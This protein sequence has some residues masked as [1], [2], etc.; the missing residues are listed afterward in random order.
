MAV[1]IIVDESRSTRPKITSIC[2]SCKNARANR[3]AWVARKKQVWKRAYERECRASDRVQG[4]Y[5]VW[6][7]QKCAHFEVDK[8]AR[9]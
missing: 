2:W 9:R 4:C 8:E 1:E 3:C 7:V 6:V 5:K